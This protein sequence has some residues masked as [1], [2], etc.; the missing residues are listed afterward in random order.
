MRAAVP[1]VCVEDLGWITPAGAQA[2]PGSDNITDVDVDVPFPNL[3]AAGGEALPLSYG[4]AESYRAI[5][6]ALTQDA[7]ASAKGATD[8]TIDTMQVRPV[9]SVWRGVVRCGAVW[10]GVVC[11][12]VAWGWVPWERLHGGCLI[13]NLS[14]REVVVLSQ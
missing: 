13:L 4:S 12:G 1:P 11:Y 14:N 5:S 3:R 9:G 2:C 8:A 7:F 10:C 6:L